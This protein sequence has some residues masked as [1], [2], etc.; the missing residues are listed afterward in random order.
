MAFLHVSKRFKTQ[1]TRFEV[2]RLYSV[3]DILISLCD[4]SLQLD[5]AFMINFGQYENEMT[6]NKNYT[7]PPRYR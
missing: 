5:I 1:E 7:L 4:S 2:T 6:A 3:P